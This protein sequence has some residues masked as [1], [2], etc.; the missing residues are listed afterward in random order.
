MT[1]HFPKDTK[2]YMFNGIVLSSQILPR[3][4]KKC[5]IMVRHNYNYVNYIEQYALVVKKEKVKMEASV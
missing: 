1:K 2:N 3:C 5:N 4:E